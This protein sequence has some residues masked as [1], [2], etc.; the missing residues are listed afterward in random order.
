[1]K[2]TIK[3]TIYNKTS[4]KNI[5]DRNFLLTYITH[6]FLSPL[7]SI[8]IVLTN[9]FSVKI[10]ITSPQAPAAPAVLQ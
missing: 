6:N 9:I 4:F 5:L 1:M 3:S 8:K 7:Y 2:L 10:L